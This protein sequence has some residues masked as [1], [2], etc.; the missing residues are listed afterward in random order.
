[1]PEILGLKRRVISFVPVITTNAYTAGYQLGGVN[2][3][4]NAVEEGAT[5]S[6]ISVAIYDA[7]KQKSAID[8]LFFNAAV[9][10]TSADAAALNISKAEMAKKYIGRVVVAAASYGAHDSNVGAD[11]ALGNINLL[12]QGA[13][14][15]DIYCVLQVQG[16]PTYAAATDLTV[17]VGLQL[18]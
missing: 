11:V 4:A 16:T 18:D 7:S 1:M 12:L 13:S 17:L 15:R 3:L 6:V 14:G 10:P 2:K 9:V 5:A 8:L